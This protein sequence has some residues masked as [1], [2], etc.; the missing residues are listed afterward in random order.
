MSLTR[1]FICALLIACFAGPGILA[2]CA[3]VRPN[4]EPVINESEARGFLNTATEYMNANPKQ[5]ARANDFFKSA[6]G[7]N[8]KLLP[9]HLGYQDS[10]F[11]YYN[12]DVAAQE[13]QK[14]EM[15]AMYE[16]YAKRYPAD[17][18]FQH[19]YGR[20][21]DKLGKRKDAVPYFK[22]ALKLD[23]K[24]YL[25]HAA[26]AKF[27]EEVDKSP[28]LAQFHKDK[29]EKYRAIQELRNAIAA[30]PSNIVLH[31]EYQ[32]LMLAAEKSRDVEPEAVLKEYE[33]R[34]KDAKGTADEPQYLYLYGRLLGQMSNPEDAKTQFEL[35]ASLNPKLPWPYDGLGTYYIL[36]AQEQGTSQK[37]AD[38]CIN[39]AM[40]MYEKAVRLDNKLLTT[41]LKLA[42]LYMN[43]SSLRQGQAEEIRTRAAGRA[44]APEEQD[45]I[46]SLLGE[47]YRLSGECKAR[48]TEML[49][50]QPQEPEVLLLTAT[51]Q[52][53]DGSY[54]LAKQAAATG[55]NLTKEKPPVDPEVRDRIEIKLTGI[56][57]DSDIFIR[58]LAENRV[59][60]GAVFPHFFFENEFRARMQSDDANLRANTIQALAAFYIGV[61]QTRDELDEKIL[62]DYEQ[63]QKTAL[64]LIGEALADGAD[65]VRLNAVKAA[66]ALGVEPFCEDIGKILANAKEPDEMRREAAL[67]LGNMRSAK[68]V[69]FLIEGL[70]D[71]SRPVR[72]YSIKGLR[73]LA[74]Q[75][76]GYD[77][78]AE[79]GKRLETA[80]KI[81]KWWE[82]NKATYQVPKP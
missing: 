61:M 31:R 78:A 77:Y 58:Q 56:M 20:M 18:M 73:D 54:F 39:K 8:Y 28:A 21:L 5:P 69:E 27:Y 72:E 76:F 82:E 12:P 64:V 14:N 24:Y 71:E 68:A 70:K 81:K 6:I 44:L 3:V 1:R 60:K 26:L 37:D 25:A 63:M 74:I 53:E 22:E 45:K 46:K 47:A 66:G 65:N 33:Q 80:E 23:D 41:K 29:S 7:S 9:A 49:A 10:F 4:K 75:T 16:K 11:E 48:I 13:K 40:Q 79:V 32:D 43:V 2:S 30:D 36:K 42:E 59:Q 15:L 50:D 17:P 67:A 52:Y 38:D 34:L 55:L 51:F 19:L 57:Q 35:A 62:A